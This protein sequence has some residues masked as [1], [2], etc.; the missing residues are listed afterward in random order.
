M[1]NN[2]SNNNTGHAMNAYIIYHS[3]LYTMLCNETFRSDWSHD[4]PF[5]IQYLHR[6][7]NRAQTGP[8]FVIGA[9]ALE[10]TMGLSLSPPTHL[11]MY[12]ASSQNERYCRRT[13]L[14]DNLI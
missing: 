7:A 8:L 10:E 11:G 13:W 2:K 4:E 9:Y 6:I 12:P 3:Q 14:L 1:L 5:L